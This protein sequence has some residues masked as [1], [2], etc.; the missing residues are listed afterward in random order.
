MKILQNSAKLKYGET[1]YSTAPPQIFIFNEVIGP[2]TTCSHTNNVL[3]PIQLRATPFPAN[4]Y[5]F[6][7]KNR[8]TRKRY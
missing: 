5:L 8:N 3:V 2:S 4:T 6:K 7:I 1:D